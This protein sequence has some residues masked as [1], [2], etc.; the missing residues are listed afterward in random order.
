MVEALEDQA[1]SFLSHLKLKGTL[2]QMALQGSPDITKL[3]HNTSVI[4]DI[5]SN[6]IHQ[7]VE[8]PCLQRKTPG[9]F[10]L[11][12][13]KSF[14]RLHYPLMAKICCELIAKSYQNER[15][16]LR[17]AYIY[18]ADQLETQGEPLQAVHTYQKLNELDLNLRFH[19]IL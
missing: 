12:L 16:V 13:A 7:I 6:W 14:E 2:E 17:D 9:K 11:D 3:Q 4:Q 19:F 8:K 18:L 5:L 15:E 1:Q 10:L